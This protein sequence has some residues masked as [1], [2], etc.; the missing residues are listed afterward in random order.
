MKYWGLPVGLPDAAASV[1]IIP[2]QDAAIKPMA[3]SA[4]EALC[5]PAG[6]AGEIVVSGAHV[7]RHYVNNPY[8]ETIHKIQVDGSTWHRTGDAGRMDDRGQLYFL[9][10]CTEI[11]YW[12]GNTIYPVILSYQL[13]HLPGISGAAVLKLGD[14][15]IV[16]IESRSRDRSSVIPTLAK[17][18]I[19]EAKIVVV[20]KLPRD[21]RHVTKIDYAA[22]RRRLQR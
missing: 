4:W 20:R 5:R 21:P 6:T 17:H 14:Q 18:G 9:G 13:M 1:R 11:V 19:P 22:L 16:V 8:A 10:R 12:L 7:L 15:I 3:A 2:W